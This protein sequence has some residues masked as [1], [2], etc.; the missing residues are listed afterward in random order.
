MRGEECDSVRIGLYFCA[1]VKIWALASQL[2]LH[3]D[4]LLELLFS[5]R[6][7]ASTCRKPDLAL[8]LL[9]VHYTFQESELLL[10]D[11]AVSLALR[12]LLNAL[13][14]LPFDEFHYLGT[15]GMVSR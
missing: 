8:S 1:R 12:T 10:D 6:I 5:N 3:S 2:Y 7:T 9:E 14:R 11:Y 15:L 4:G 13:I